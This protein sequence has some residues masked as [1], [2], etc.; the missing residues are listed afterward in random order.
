LLEEKPGAFTPLAIAAQVQC[1]M[2]EIVAMLPCLGRRRIQGGPRG[3]ASTLNDATWSLRPNLA[4]GRDLCSFAHPTRPV[5]TTVD[6]SPGQRR[7]V[8]SYWLGCELRIRSLIP[9]PEPGTVMDVHA[10]LLM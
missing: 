9:A 4:P 10:T 5:T 1:A 6:P 3:R 2:M 7:M 8:D